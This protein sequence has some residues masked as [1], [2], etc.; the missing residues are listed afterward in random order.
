MGQTPLHRARLGLAALLLMLG[1]A[2]ASVAADHAAAPVLTIDSAEVSADW[3]AGFLPEDA[4]E[5]RM[6]PLPDEWARWRGHDGSPLWYRVRFTPP[7]A[8]DDPLALFVE[9][10]CSTLEVHLN[11][12]LLFRGG[13][14]VDPITHNCQYPQLI[15]LPTAML[16]KGENQIDLRVAGYPIARVASRLR[17]GGLSALEIGPQSLLAPKLNRQLAL[18][19]SLPQALSA[20][21]ILLG[22]FMF[23]LGWRYRS[24][25]YLAYLGIVLVGWGL[26]TSR[27]WWRE[28]PLP[29]AELEFLLCALVALI[30][31]AAVQFLLR[32]AGWRHPWID[33]GLALQCALLPLTLVLAGP[34]RLHFWAS[35]W[36]LLLV[37]EVCAAA[38][39]C[40][41]RLW[42][43]YGRVPWRLA[44]VLAVLSVAVVIEL[45]AQQYGLPHWPTRIAQ[46]A[47]PLTFILLGLQLVM[48]H[49]QALQLAAD[50]ARAGAEQRVKDTTA[51]IERDFDRLTEQRIEQVTQRE[52]KRIAADLH[53]DL[54]AKLLT[55]IHTSED[56]RLATLAREALEEMRLSVRGLT[57][58][59]V[60]LA[61][62]LGDWRAELMSRLAQ[63]GI[64]GEWG[65]DDEFSQT[66]S[67]RSYVQTTRI[68]REAT[69]NI[70]KHS[71]ASRCSIQSSL[72]EGDFVLTIQDNGRGISE[73]LDGRLDRGNGMASM[74]SR[75]K[76]MQGQCL[77]ESGPGFGTVMRL[78]LP[79]DQSTVPRP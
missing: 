55:I 68:L 31:L 41:H 37:I 43:V 61:D 56:P 71:M 72:H 53:D 5:V 30:A 73:S 78:T 17:A 35:A 45:V 32:F 79:L 22:G 24:E 10:V 38:A 15:P 11:G 52:R 29:N 46:V 14:L 13:Q 58:K 67:A 40:L 62:A 7:P 27:R 60:R 12:Q 75:A 18:N 4:A 21:L 8:A 51:A 39:F 34:A 44:G 42:R 59:P 3:P 50:A 57:G 77:F 54:G 64:E 69:S 28:P 47:M 76:Q 36:F 23:A 33:R 25:S 19:V 20:T 1:S 48:R 74:K 49:G 2:G 70:I 9:R 16:R 65:A 26:A 66:L 63:A 6:R